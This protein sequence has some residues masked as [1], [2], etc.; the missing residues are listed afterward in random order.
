MI[1]AGQPG[2]I[3]VIR[4][5]ARSTKIVPYRL[6]CRKPQ[7][8]RP[9]PCIFPAGGEGNIITWSNVVTGK[10]DTP[11]LAAKKR[12]TLRCGLNVMVEM[13]EV[14]WVIPVFEFNLSRVVTSISGAHLLFSLL[15]QGVDVDAAGDE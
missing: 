2:N 6:L 15:A 1:A 14:G 8:S 9:I 13:E 10:I 11:L 3:V 4:C 12:A 5:A 7:S